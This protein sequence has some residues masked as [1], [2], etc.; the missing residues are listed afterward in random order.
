MAVPVAFAYVRRRGRTLLV[1]RPDGELLG[2]LWSLPGGE[3]PPGRARAE[4]L[5]DAVAAQTGLRVDVDD[6]VAPLAHTFS[7]RRWSG[8]VIRCVPR[9]RVRPS[10]EVRWVRDAEIGNLPLV[11]AHRRIL[12]SLRERPPLESYA[13]SRRRGT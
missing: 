5:R 7:H 13:E 12:E 11:P 1:R 4:A 8:S 3:V 10:A 6:E 9:G 2:G